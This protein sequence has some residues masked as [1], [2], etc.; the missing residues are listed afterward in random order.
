MK[1]SADLYRPPG[2]LIRPVGL[3]TLLRDPD[4]SPHPI[5]TWCEADKSVLV[6]VSLQIGHGSEASSRFVS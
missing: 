6:A 2:V 4:R 5:G 3:R 1:N